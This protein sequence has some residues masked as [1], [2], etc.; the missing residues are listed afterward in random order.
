MSKQPK[1]KKE[2]TPSRRRAYKE[3]VK[4]PPGMCSVLFKELGPIFAYEIK[5]TKS[6]VL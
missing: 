2:K 1:Q 4:K 3:L 6:K 5:E